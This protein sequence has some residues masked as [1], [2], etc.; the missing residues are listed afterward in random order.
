MARLTIADV[1]HG[2]QRGGK[3]GCRIGERHVAAGEYERANAC[4]MQR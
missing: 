3:Q 2:G 4:R 1:P